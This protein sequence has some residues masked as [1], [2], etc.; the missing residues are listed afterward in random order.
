M[1]LAFMDFKDEDNRCFM[2]VWIDVCIELIKLLLCISTPH[3]M[4]QMVT[5]LLLIIMMKQQ[6]CKFITVMMV[7]SLSAQLSQ[8]KT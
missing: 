2:A 4:R 3:T 7:L 1:F 8:H 6:M 5:E